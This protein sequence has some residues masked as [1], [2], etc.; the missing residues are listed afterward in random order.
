[1][2]KKKK[3]THPFSPKKRDRR[4][5]DVFSDIIMMTANFTVELLKWKTVKQKFGS[6]N[7]EEI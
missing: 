7:L 1:M 3:E 4:E 2:Q 6:R 5:L